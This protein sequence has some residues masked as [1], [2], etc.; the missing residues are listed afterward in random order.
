MGSRYAVSISLSVGKAGGDIVILCFWQMDVLTLKMV[1]SG[2][3]STKTIVVFNNEAIVHYDDIRSGEALQGFPTY[4]VRPTSYVIS[5]QTFHKSL[6]VLVQDAIS[7]IGIRVS[8][9]P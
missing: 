7:S 2:G 9:R 3:M 1:V 6:R 8:Y 4:N 5:S